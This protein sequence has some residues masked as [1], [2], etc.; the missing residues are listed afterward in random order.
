[1]QR[2]E[3]PLD[4]FLVPV[5]H[6]WDR[7]WLLLSAGSLEKKDYNLMTVGWGGFGVMWGKP[8][9]MIVVRPT[10]YTWEFMEKSDTFTLCAFGEEHRKKLS[11]CGSHS[12]RNEDKVQGSGLTPIRSRLVPSPGFEE[13]ELIVECRKTYF[14]DLEPSH[15]LDPAAESK[16][17]NKDYHRMYFGEILAVT[18]TAAWR[19]GEPS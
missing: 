15:F 19:R 3:I 11:W 1:M 6:V 12:G 9:A 14:D 5:V 13:A 2:T 4:D 17:P 18:G 16:Y 8:L 7:Q 10:R